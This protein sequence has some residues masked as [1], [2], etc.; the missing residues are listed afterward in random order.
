MAEKKTTSK[1]A[2]K[3]NFNV[4]FNQNVKFNEARY[5]KGETLEVS[6]EE[7][8]NLLIADVIEKDD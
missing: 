6:Q 8:E 7:Y 5:K 4:K 3:G 2:K 1:G